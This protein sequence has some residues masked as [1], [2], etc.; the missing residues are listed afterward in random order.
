MNAAMQA[1]R[2]FVL[3]LTAAASICALRFAP[4]EARPR[5]E[6]VDPGARF[7]E[8][9]EA[10]RKDGEY[11]VHFALTESGPVHEAVLDNPGLGPLLTDVLQARESTRGD[12]Q[13]STPR[14]IPGLISGAI[15]GSTSCPAVV[16]AL[17]AGGCMLDDLVLSPV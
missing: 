10:R 7:K 4:C 6:K 13:R 17:T 3:T 9:V 16:M 15:H 2:T 1:P 14:P 8:M 12:R 5:P 11:V